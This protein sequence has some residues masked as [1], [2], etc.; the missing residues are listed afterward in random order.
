MKN[1]NQENLDRPVAL[2]DFNEL[3]KAS[4]RDFKE[5]TEVSGKRFKEFTNNVS[6]T[7]ATKEDLKESAEELSNKF[8]KMFANKEDL[9]ETERRIIEKTQMIRDE[10]LSSNDKIAGELSIVRQEQSADTIGNIRR[11]DKIEEHETR[12]TRVETKL[13]MSP[14]SI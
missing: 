10:I 12:I 3:R 13:D 5:F 9:K 1:K 2:K 6:R 8:F 14:V 7:F 4:K 11:D